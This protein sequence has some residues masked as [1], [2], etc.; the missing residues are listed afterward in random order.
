MSILALVAV[1]YAGALLSAYLVIRNLDKI[2]EQRFGLWSA[3]GRQLAVTTES[4]SPE[5]EVN[6]ITL[7]RE[8]RKDPTFTNLER[9]QVERL[10]LKIAV[11]STQ[12]VTLNASGG[13]PAPPVEQ[14]SLLRTFLNF[15]YPA[16]SLYSLKR[17]IG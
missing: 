5:P 10:C 3:S 15:T 7:R 12:S 4:P 8:L 16:G 2:T 13:L 11:I 17:A 6:G 14:I 9:E 1:V